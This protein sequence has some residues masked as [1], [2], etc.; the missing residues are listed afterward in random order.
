MSS[1]PSPLQLVAAFAQIQSLAR[2]PLSA[3]GEE[4]R[5]KEREEKKKEGRKKEREGRREKENR[6]RA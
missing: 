3:A 1:I 2:E 6:E 5:E 4:G